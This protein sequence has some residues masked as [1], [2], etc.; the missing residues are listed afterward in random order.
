M[1]YSQ[2][3]LFEVLGGPIHVDVVQLWAVQFYGRQLDAIVECES[4]NAA[5]SGFIHLQ[6]FKPYAM[7]EI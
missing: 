5:A 7:A 2:R 6:L 1:T 4:A 3:D